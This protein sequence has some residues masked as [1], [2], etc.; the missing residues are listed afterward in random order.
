[1]RDA[2]RPA[3]QSK[4]DQQQK[5]PWLKSALSQVEHKASF[6]NILN[7]IA[8]A[9]PAPPRSRAIM[10]K[11]DSSMSLTG[12]RS[13]EFEASSQ[14]SGVKSDWDNS[15]SI[16]LSGVKG[17]HSS[18]DN[19][20]GV[21][22]SE[23]TTDSFSE[24][25]VN[26][27]LQSDL[28]SESS[29]LTGLNMSSP[30]PAKNWLATRQLPGVLASSGPAAYETIDSDEIPPDYIDKSVAEEEGDFTGL[31]GVLASSEDWSDSSVESSPNMEEESAAARYDN[32]HV[33][34]TTDIEGYH[35]ST[36]LADVE[37]IG[38]DKSKD[39]KTSDAANNLVPQ[40]EHWPMLA[41]ATDRG[42]K[43]AF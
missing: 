41:D 12:V 13:D 7:G 40:N 36:P 8:V 27:W 33:T 10:K 26:D 18:Q 22:R 42:D 21:L 2:K 3:I 14:L 43:V 37:P 24:D 20:T 30:T 1:M 38:F 35:H 6:S 25:K 17:Y 32:V 23:S 9:T 11:K 29:T 34:G 4:E 31:T 28:L 15:S 39:M 5:W 19:L 16:Q